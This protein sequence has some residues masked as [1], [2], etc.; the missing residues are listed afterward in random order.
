[1]LIDCTFKEGMCKLP[2]GNERK[3]YLGNTSNLVSHPVGVESKSINSL[4]NIVK[5]DKCCTRNLVGGYNTR[6]L[7]VSIDNS[8]RLGLSINNSTRL[9]VSLVNSTRT[10]GSMLLSMILKCHTLFHC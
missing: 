5:Q 7:D 9:N 1:V 6:R 10:R 2:N 4:L 3:S 8:A